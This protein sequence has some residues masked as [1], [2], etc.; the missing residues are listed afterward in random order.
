M[1]EDT[2]L[3]CSLRRSNTM[4]ANGTVRD[5]GSDG[6]LSNET[7]SYENWAEKALPCFTAI[8]VCI[9]VT[10]LVG[11]S[12]VVLVMHKY[13]KLFV[14]MKT[15]YVINQSVLD[16]VTSSILILASLFREDLLPLMDGVAA[17]LF[18]RLWLTQI[19]LWGLIISSTYNL[20][21][22]SFERY[23]AIAHPFWH[24][25]S[26]SHTKIR[27]SIV[28]IWLFGITFMASFMLPTTRMSQGRCFRS[29]F[30][31][32][33]QVAMVVT[34][35]QNIVNVVLPIAV[36]CACYARI[37]KTLKMRVSPSEQAGSST[38]ASTGLPLSSEGIMI[39]S[40]STTI[41][42]ALQVRKNARA[43]ANPPTVNQKQDMAATRNMNT[44]F[45]IVTACFFACWMPNRIYIF[46]YHIGVVSHFR[47]TYES[48]VIL[49]FLNCCINPFIYAAKYK[50]FK[51]GFSRLIRC[52]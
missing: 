10:G 29:Y 3:H 16:A 15:A 9:G 41:H 13:R 8:K 36:H 31:P 49:V 38:A 14:N 44:S 35:L 37:L 42:N 28:A 22:I 21:A 30:W 39:T 23:V 1:A 33:R 7:R 4:A 25:T 26:F 51:K 46:I 48:S 50:P 52:G 11:N 27:S 40:T 5:I 24:M 43:P 18:C 19:L 12:I 20:M 47:E 34:A 6:V 32:S 17:E 45:A 2:H